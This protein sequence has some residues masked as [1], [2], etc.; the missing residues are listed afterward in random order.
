MRDGAVA[1]SIGDSND[2]RTLEYAGGSGRT[3]LL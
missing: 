2:G 1:L 3:K